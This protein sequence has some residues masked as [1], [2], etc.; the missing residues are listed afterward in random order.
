MRFWSSQS[1]HKTSGSVKPID[2]D[3][4][5]HILNIPKATVSMTQES[6][7]QIS[8]SV[9]LADAEEFDCIPNFSKIPVIMPPPS[10]MKLRNKSQILNTLGVFLGQGQL[11]DEK[12]TASDDISAEKNPWKIS[13]FYST[14][15]H[16]Q[17]HAEEI[18][19]IVHETLKNAGYTGTFSL[20]SG[21]DINTIGL[22]EPKQE[23]Y[24]VLNKEISDEL[25]CSLGELAFPFVGVVITPNDWL[26]NTERGV[27]TGDSEKSETELTK[28]GHI[29]IAVSS[30]QRKDQTVYKSSESPDGS[31]I[32]N[33][34]LEGQGR[35]EDEGTENVCE[36]GNENEG[37]DGSSGGGSG[38]GGQGGN[39]YTSKDGGNGEDSGDGDG[40]R[41]SQGGNE[42]GGG[43]GG[44]PEGGR[45]DNNASQSIVKIHFVSSITSNDGDEFST[46]TCDLD[47]SDNSSDFSLYRC[48]HD[49]FRSTLMAI[50]SNILEICC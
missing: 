40:S 14:P 25:H 17:S 16:A 2:A 48:V 11:V 35:S 41:D 42:G 50:L 45:S 46:V 26:Q 3:E 29:A 27:G 12:R 37:R 5:D 15:D 49:R 28:L 38:G 23:I 47:V 18:K 31:G 20:H 19:P 33:D 7:H 43:G 10:S 13:T 30:L 24:I 32:A 39:R 8:G 22:P 9:K 1:H 36:S 6:C 44:D 21:F 4:L 34:N